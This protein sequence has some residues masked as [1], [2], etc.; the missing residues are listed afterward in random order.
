MKFK[1]PTEE[2]EE[3]NVMPLIDVVLMLLIFFMVSSHMNTLERVTVSLPVADKAKVPEDARDRQVI[4]VESETGGRVTY[5]MNL[6]KMD[7]KEL[8]AEIV[9]LHEADEN[10]KVYLRADRQVRHKH[11]KAVMEACAEAGIA[12]IIFGVV[13]SGS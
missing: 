3:I 8:S 10:M 6:R 7:I 12:D 4:T 1:I 9:R 13:E 5:Y 11:I 2:D